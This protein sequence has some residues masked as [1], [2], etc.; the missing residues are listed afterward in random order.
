VREFRSRGSVRGAV[1]NDR[2]YR[3]SKRAIS[4][5]MP[6]K[7]AFTWDGECR[8]RARAAKERHKVHC[9]RSNNSAKRRMALDAVARIRLFGKLKL[10]KCARA[11]RRPGHFCV[12]AEERFFFVVI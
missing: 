1:S 12:R 4:S 11:E 5:A 6:R 3:D 2:P 10:T 8:R 7:R 9:H